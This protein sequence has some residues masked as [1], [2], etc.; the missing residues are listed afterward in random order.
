MKKYMVA[1][2]FALLGCHVVP[3]EPP[4]TPSGTSKVSAYDETTHHLVAKT[5]LTEEDLASLVVVLNTV[6]QHSLAEKVSNNG[7][8]LAFC[9]CT[10]ATVVSNIR[11][12]PIKFKED[13]DKHKS[14]IMPNEVQLSMCAKE[15]GIS[16]SR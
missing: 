8:L 2:M 6:C 3:P 4:A 13:L 1:A 7:A 14:E 15:A 10:S 12:I 11:S 5:P 9:S 16:I